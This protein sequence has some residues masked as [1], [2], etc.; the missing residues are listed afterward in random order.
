MEKLSYTH[1]VATNDT[2][3]NCYF[4]LLEQTLKDNN[5]TD[6]PPQIFNCDETGVSLNHTL[7]SVIAVKG[8]KHPCA[9]TSG[10]KKQVTVLACTSATGYTIPPLVI[11]ARKGLVEDL[12]I[13]EIPGTAYG[14]S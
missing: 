13:D 1:S 12:T 7:S 4:D 2:I 3:I 14:L 5:L 6:F 8:Q 9:I 11:F 10:N